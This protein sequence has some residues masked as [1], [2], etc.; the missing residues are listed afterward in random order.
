MPV[1]LIECIHDRGSSYQWIFGGPM[2]NKIYYREFYETI[3]DIAKHPVVRQMKRYPHHG[4]T[5]CYKHC[6]RVAYQNYVLCRKLRL[7]ARAAAR[8]GMLH[9]LFLYDWHTHAK[10]TGE[11]WHGLKHPEKAYRNARK[12]FDLNRTESDIIRTFCRFPRTKEGW[13]TVLTDKYSGLFETGRRR[14]KEKR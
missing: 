10:E 4:N 7:D 5:S 14:R 2:M 3:K 9:D 13:I 8:A 6:L 1:F 12:I 11:R